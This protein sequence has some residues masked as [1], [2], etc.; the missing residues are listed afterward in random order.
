MC[1]LCIAVQSNAVLIHVNL[2]KIVIDGAIH[3][4]LG[5]GYIYGVLT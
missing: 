1:E 4:C 3:F 5:E 2:A